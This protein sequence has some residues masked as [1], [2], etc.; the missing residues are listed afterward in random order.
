MLAN[1]S[2]TLV[3]TIGFEWMLVGIS[4]LCF[5]YA[6]MLRFLKAPP[7]KEEKKVGNGQDNLAM[8]HDINSLEMAKTSI[9]NNTENQNSNVAAQNDATRL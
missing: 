9:N 2:G 4:F 5:C 1:H 8:T 6:P 7:T 3:N